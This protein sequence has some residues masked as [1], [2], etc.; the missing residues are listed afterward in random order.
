MNSSELEY[1]LKKYTYKLR[2]AKN[3][4][5][6]ESY[7]QK[8]QQYH[9]LGRTN[10]RGGDGHDAAIAKA[11][12]AFEAIKKQLGESSQSGEIAA[13]F[14]NKAKAAKAEFDRLQESHNKL[15][16]N[17]DAFVKYVGEELPKKL[18]LLQAAPCKIDGLTFPEF[19]AQLC[20][21]SVKP[22]QSAQGATSSDVVPAAAPVATGG[23]S[24]IWW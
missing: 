7:Q 10:Q 17:N 16:S 9:S 3:R 23:K 22:T 2:H 1:K 8:L 5:E 19:T 6:A 24:S 15:C 21:A 12:A 14:N 18:E 13:D 11:D 4:R 20:G